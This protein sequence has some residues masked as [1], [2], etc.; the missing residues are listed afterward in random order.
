[1][2]TNEQL[3]ALY[4]VAFWRAS[5]SIGDIFHYGLYVKHTG[6]TKGT[7]Y[8]AIQRPGW[9]LEVK[10]HNVWESATAVAATK[11][12]TF[13][14]SVN[15]SYLTEF[16]KEV[17]IGTSPRAGDG[18]WRCNHWMRDAVALMGEKGD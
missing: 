2:S 7:L 12:G 3:D 1:M 14:S 11:I 13:D 17:P 6:A 18:G 5:D 15:Q 8:H 10:S 16:L 4:M 9:I